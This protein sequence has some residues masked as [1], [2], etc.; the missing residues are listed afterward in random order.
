MAPPGCRRCVRALRL[1]RPAAHRGAASGPFSR[2]PGVSVP[3]LRRES[4][5]RWHAAW[6]AHAERVSVRRLGDEISQAL[7]FGRLEP[8]PLAHYRSGDVLVS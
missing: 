4:S 1:R 2:R 5:A 8:P 6:V 3:Q 7:A